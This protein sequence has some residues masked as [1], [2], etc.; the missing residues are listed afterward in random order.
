M[1][2]LYFSGALIAAHLLGMP[3]ASEASK[4]NGQLIDTPSREVSIF[5]VPLM[6][7]SEGD[8]RELRDCQLR[9]GNDFCLKTSSIGGIIARVP[10]GGCERFFGNKT[11]I[12][13]DGRVFIYTANRCQGGN[14][15]K[16]IQ[17]GKLDNYY[18]YNVVCGNGKRLKTYYQLITG[19]DNAT[20][21]SYDRCVVNST[22]GIDFGCN[23]WGWDRDILPPSR[24]KQ[25]EFGMTL[26]EIKEAERRRKRSIRKKPASIPMRRI[27]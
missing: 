6:F 3:L 19:I 21:L 4:A 8:D 20:R 18:T 25:Y 1:R 2:D 27:D 11:C 7:T 15:K 22:L 12:Y 13:A 10:W 9:H 16:W 24:W 17:V 14:H 5:S 26:K 23:S